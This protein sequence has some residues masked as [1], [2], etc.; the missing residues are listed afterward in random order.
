MYR[1]LAITLLCLCAVFGAAGAQEA[2]PAESVARALL[3]ENFESL[4]PDEQIEALDQRMSSLP[5]N[6]PASVIAWLATKILE[7]AFE[8]A[9]YARASAKAKSLFPKVDP[10][11][12]DEAAYVEF[13]QL[14]AVAH[15]RV[16]D[17]D[18][19]FA[20]LEALR[21]YQDT[22]ESE[23]AAE[24]A[25]FIFADIY[26]QIGEFERAAEILSRMLA[27][28]EAADDAATL[29]ARSILANNLAFA[30]IGAGDA[31][32]ALA[33]LEEARRLNA[34]YAGLADADAGLVQAMELF[35]DSNIGEA[36]LLK[37]DYAALAPIAERVARGGAEIGN[38]YLEAIGLRQQA[39]AAAGLGA[40]EEALSHFT[41]AQ[42]IAEEIGEEELLPKIYLGHA[43]ALERAGEFERAL[44]A[45][46][47]YNALRDKTDQVRVQGRLAMITSDAA[48]RVRDQELEL[49]RAE[50]QYTQS[51]IRRDRGIAVLS[52]AAALFLASSLAALGYAYIQQHRAKTELAKRERDA[53]AA[54]RAKSEFL[55]NMSHEIRTPMNGV[56]GMAQLLRQTDLT[57]KQ[58][59]YA[60]TIYNSGTALLTIINDILDFSKIEAGKLE[61][62]PAPFNL[63]EAVEDVAILLGP[64]AREKGLEL[65]ARCDPGAPEQVVGDAGRIRQVLTNLIGNALKFTHE[66]YVL[67]EIRAE[68]ADGLA[69]LRLEV[70]DTGIGIPEDKVDRIFDQFT[71]A[72]ATT[73]KRFGG[74]GLGLSISKGII[75]AMDGRIGVESK[76]GEGSVFWAEFTLPVSDAAPNAP[77]APVE[78]D[79][80]PILIVDD[81][82]VNRRILLEQFANWGA[83]PIAAESGERALQLLREAAEA[84]A[85]I[86]LVVTDFHMPEMDGLALLQRIRS[87]DRIKDAKVIVLASVDDK[88]TAEAFKALG[89]AAY[90]Q[91]P[92]R[93]AELRMALYAAIANHNL[94]AMRELA[95]RSPH[96]A[97]DRATA[98]AAP[99]RVLVAEDNHVNRVVLEN[100][101]EGVECDLIFA[102][103]GKEAY[104][105]FKGERPQ[106]ILMDVSMPVMDGVEATKAIRSHEHRAGWKQTPIVALTAHTLEGARES[107]LDCGMNDYLAKP[108]DKSAVQAM[109]ARWLPR[110][111]ET[112]P[113]GEEARQA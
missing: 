95:R 109:L 61:L 22:Y 96:I 66:G 55:A 63:A 92:A 40:V 21:D 82:E 75:E 41:D 54:S 87:E 98:A 12:L 16:S 26:L 25:D 44:A 99:P 2:D 48:R 68:I 19:A 108:L 46:R 29:D 62:D 112:R 81:L 56:L 70:A 86:P 90:L 93:S 35:L 104:E 18:A 80:I 94:A 27:A 37:E 50:Q 8:E 52:V 47:K 113:D 74:T 69:R 64:T 33:Q 58:A 43:Q 85:P 79:N 83:A 23:L 45:L 105:L 72:E 4:A 7:A 49:L 89:A 24:T 65:I 5:A 60:D 78:L 31:D 11:G 88:E 106:L 102:A 59:M 30:Y 10:E 91:K 110:P 15:T 28:S 1:V 111:H 103:D 97:G 3:P 84:E 100:M 77:A 36:L 6:A 67:V 107:Y 51:I 71:Q 76:L 39:A 32:R 53:Q 9:H 73:T 101:L 38:K 20:V 57:Q 14:A 13:A 34:A 42:R 17:F